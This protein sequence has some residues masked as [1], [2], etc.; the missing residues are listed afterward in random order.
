M[1]LKNF[2]FSKKVALHPKQV[3]KV[4]NNLRPFPTTIEIDLTN[5]CNHRCSFCVWGEHISTDKS[6]LKKDV[7]EKC[8]LNMRQMG[9]KAITF[10][11]GGEPM[12][13]K[14]FSEILE[15]T[16]SL[17]YDCGLITNGSVITEKNAHFLIKNLKWI[18]FSISGGD[19]ESYQAVQGKDQF[20]LV[21]KNINL[22]SKTKIEK[23]SNLKI[24]VRMLITKE[25]IH[26]LIKLS[27]ILK[28]IEG[29]NFLQI[30][31]DHSN[32]DEGKFWHG[33]L[34]KSERE[35]A[36]K[37]LFD[38]NID[39]RTSG[40]EILNTSNKDNDKILNKPS[41]CFAH[42]FQIAIMADGSVSYCKN[43]RFDEKFIVGNI[44]SQNIFEIWNS[45]KNIEFEKWVKPSNC[46]LLCKNIRV[47]LGM[48]DIKVN[49][50]K[51]KNFVFSD[52]NLKDYDNNYPK[53]P[54]D[55]NFVG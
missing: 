1:K 25:N 15:Y 13:H 14:N 52:K 31:P 7:I 12:I 42:F 41:K 29:I 33:E 4:F 40:F 53:D 23:N 9:S 10:T 43:A 50:G 51:Q 18:R 19:K 16:K 26:T 46:G 21:C 47:N 5:H 36:E 28:D 2:D 32:E 45:K 27:E 49:S 55:K 44:N 54:L 48:E 8:I 37:I 22:L 34:V 24:G 11:G 20:D 35:K 38:N 30:A 6:T 17:G 3:E 39:L